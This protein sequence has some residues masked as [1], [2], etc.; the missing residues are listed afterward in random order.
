MWTHRLS[1]SVH[2]VH[3]VHGVY[4]AHGVLSPSIAL[5]ECVRIGTMML[6]GAQQVDEVPACEAERLP[7]FVK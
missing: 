5:A 2:S 1:W 3:F 7:D 4:Q 6:H